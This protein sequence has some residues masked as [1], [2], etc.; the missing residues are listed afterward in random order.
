MTGTTSSTTRAARPAK[1]DFDERPFI[2][3]WEMTQACDLVCVH[4]R[5][6]AQ[7]RRS[8]LE[9]ST[10][11]AERLIDQI[12]AMQ[13]PVFVL[14]GGDPLKRPDVYHLVEYATRQG[15]R[16]SLTPS[17]TPLLT[18]EAIQQL[19]ACGLARLAVSLDGSTAEI[20]DAFRGVRGSYERTLQA[21]EWARAGGLPVQLN[22]T[23]TR[24]N[25][26]NFEE[27]VRLLERL[28]IVLWSVFFLVP[29]GR[30]QTSDLISAEEFEEVF[31]KL[32]EVARRAPFDI[33][34]TEAQHYRR[35]VA[36]RRAAERRAASATAYSATRSPSQ[37]P[38]PAVSAAM[39]LDGSPAA[40]WAGG[41]ASGGGAAAR[42]PGLP[43]GIGRAPRGLN[44]AKGFVFVSHAG[45]VFPSG[46]L[47]TPAGNI[48]RQPLAEIYRHSP[49]F[50]ALRDSSNLQG[51]CGVCEFRE[52]C[53]GSR[54]RAFALTGDPFAEEPCCVYQ[55]GTVAVAG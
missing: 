15:V 38:S 53:G 45:E 28:E 16:T 13:V 6:C 49:L 34:T 10:S 37:F 19:H 12:A 17:A 31:A 26:G 51:K 55:P 1:L 3:I 21:I 52:I 39:A 23:I 4:C 29:T 22:T 7:P 48:R 8:A 18:Q 36:Q 33:K 24:R 5:A 46:F 27:M 25:L 42:N 50:V 54:A 2:V 20:H 47:P 14:T 40:S 35:Y 41:A 44:D 32:Y 11:E 30:G 43:D 9:L